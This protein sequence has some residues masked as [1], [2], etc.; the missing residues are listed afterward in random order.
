M[1]DEFLSQYSCE[2][3]KCKM[4]FKIMVTVASIVITVKNSLDAAVSF[5]VYALRRFLRKTYCRRYTH[6]HD[7]C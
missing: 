1:I 2:T 7:S 3:I 5:F 4:Y 6:K